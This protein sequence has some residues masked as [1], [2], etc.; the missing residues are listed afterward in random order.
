MEENTYKKVFHY[1]QTSSVPVS[2]YELSHVTGKSRVSVHTALKKLIVNGDIEKIGVSPRVHYVLK[3]TIKRV[4][5]DLSMEE[6][7]RRVQAIFKN[8]PIAYAGILGSFTNGVIEAGSTI[9][10][11]VGFH[12]SF[13][14]LSLTAIERALTEVLNMKVDL[15][16]DQGANKYIKSSMLSSLTIIYGKT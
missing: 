5:T 1:I 2:P 4:S 3:G 15:I 16:T 8:Y 11:M 14:I 7:E 13:P 10:M 12:Q 9:N 6:I